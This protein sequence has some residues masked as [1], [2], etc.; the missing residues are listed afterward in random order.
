MRSRIWMGRVGYLILRYRAWVCRGSRLNKKLLSQMLLLAE[1]LLQ[2]PLKVQFAESMQIIVITHTCDNTSDLVWVSPPA[3]VSVHSYCTG[4][5][6]P[7]IRD[8]YCCNRGS[9]AFIGRRKKQGKAYEAASI[10]PLTLLRS[11]PIRM[12]IDWLLY[13]IFMGLIPVQQGWSFGLLI[14]C[15]GKNTVKFASCY[16]RALLFLHMA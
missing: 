10:L 6:P 9:I 15:A 3:M 16:N 5:K 1:L 13:W 12:T 7:Q 2:N 4:G 8:C 14:P 11:L